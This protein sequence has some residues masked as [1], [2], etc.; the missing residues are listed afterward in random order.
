MKAIFFKFA[1]IALCAVAVVSCDDASSDGDVTVG[2]TTEVLYGSLSEN[3]TLAANTTYELS[4]AY[5]V[6]SGATLT[7]EEGVQIIAQDDSTVDY[8]LI[9]QG[10]KIDARGTA[11]NPIVMTSELKEHGAWGGFHI[12]GY[13]K[14]NCGSGAEGTITA[15]S[16][17]GN[18]TYGGDNDADNSGTL[19]YIR[20]E[21]AGYAFSEDSEANGFSF[22]GV[23]S[24]TTLEYLQ[25]YKGGD[26]GFEW[27]GGCVDAKYLIATDNND[28]SFDWTY[29][30]RGKIQYAIAEQGEGCDCLIEADSN[31]ESTY[32]TVVSHVALSN[33]TF[34]GVDKSSSSSDSFVKVRVG[35]EIEFYNAILKGAKNYAFHISG[36]RTH[37]SI[38]SGSSKFAGI[39][40]D[41]TTASFTTAAFYSDL[42]SD[43]GISFAGTT[44]AAA[45][46]TPVSVDGFE[47]TDFVGAVGSVDWTSGWSLAL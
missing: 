41:N 28:D 25:A 44:S 17:I 43:L 22:Y 11:S 19:S 40:A 9:E 16:E 47:A 5:T 7:I 1:T 14:I 45:S 34:T 21:Y 24:G 30:Y 33:V 4:G 32:N 29:G 10:A 18:S 15:K 2:G 6:E 3:K 35:S 38:T 12:C 39:Y 46:A 31:S 37:E 23:G 42:G 20:I 8:I 26:D 36:D 13:A 27:F